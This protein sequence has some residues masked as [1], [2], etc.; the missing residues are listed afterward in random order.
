LI[1]EREF[2]L[3][4]RLIC[5][6]FLIA[7]QS[8]AS[9]QP[10]PYQRALLEQPVSRLDLLL[11]DAN[12]NLTD[13]AS[14][15]SEELENAEWVFDLQ[16]SPTWL[17]EPNWRQINDWPEGYDKW[18]A[19]YE[20]DFMLGRSSFIYDSESHGFLLKISLH[21]EFPTPEYISDD[22]DDSEFL[23]RLIAK[24][25]GQGLLKQNREN[26]EK[27]CKWM[28][29]RATL[30]QPLD[31]VH[32][33]AHYKHWPISNK[34]SEMVRRDTSFLVEIFGRVSLDHTIFS[35]VRAKAQDWPRPPVTLSC[36]K[37]NNVGDDITVSYSG[38]WKMIEEIYTQK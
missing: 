18:L 36:A 4:R 33:D 29:A 28:L 11:F 10:K 9:A 24:R 13:W 20:P 26:F 6:I 16:N 17:A 21:Y 23:A 37:T 7:L 34:M 8:E 31:F 1:L 32:V 14:G 15:W 19:E 5:L 12:L 3:V 30:T 22:Y 2:R 25:S 38:P 27:L 35:E